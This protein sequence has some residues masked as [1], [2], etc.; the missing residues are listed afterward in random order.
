VGEHHLSVSN[1]NDFVLIAAIRIPYQI[2][3]CRGLRHLRYFVAVAEA[4]SLRKA[5]SSL[6]V[7]E[8][9]VSQQV[10]DRLAKNYS[11]GLGTERG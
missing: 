1:E 4:L 9:A 10:A 2:A 6:S 8:P 7:S 11:I 5:A 3:A